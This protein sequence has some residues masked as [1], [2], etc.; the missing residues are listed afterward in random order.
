M[1]SCGAWCCVGVTPMAQRH[2]GHHPTRVIWP[3]HR[4]VL[5]N[6]LCCPPMPMHLEHVSLIVD[7]YD[8]A[9][10]FFVQGL[11]FEVVEDSRALTTH[12]GRPKRWVVVRPPGAS[13]GL[14]L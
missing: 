4:V 7:D 2:A 5:G 10:A 14:L 8:A 6:L 13:S 3:R 12:G 11:G 9:I 1:G